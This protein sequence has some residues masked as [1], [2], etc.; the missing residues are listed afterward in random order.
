MRTEFGQ[1]VR[2]RLTLRNMLEHLGASVQRAIH[3]GLLKFIGQ[4]A[5]DR[6]GIVLGKCDCSRLF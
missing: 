2:S 1:M 4:H 5:G 6:G 3:V